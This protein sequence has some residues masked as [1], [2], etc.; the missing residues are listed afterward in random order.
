M[1]FAISFVGNLLAQSYAGK[2]NGDHDLAEYRADKSSG[3]RPGDRVVSP[4]LV[5]W[6]R[7]D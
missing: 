1:R 4:A 5:A 6:K 2:Y 3:S 7:R